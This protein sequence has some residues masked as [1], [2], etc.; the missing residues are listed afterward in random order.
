MQR[1]RELAPGVLVATSSFAT[2]TSTVVAGRDG[3]CLVIDPATTVAELAGLA[4]DLAAA[5]LHPVAGF[6]THPH[7]DHILWSDELGDV[8]RYAAPAAA[9]AA[10]REREEM[11]PDLA[12]SA[13]G[14]DLD[15]FAKLTA[16]PQDADRI[17]WDGPAARLI[18]HNAH[19]PGHTAVFLPELGVLVA[20][21][22][23]SDLEMPI[24][25]MTQPEQFAEYRAGL[26]RLAT[27]GEN[28]AGENAV[29]GESTVAGEGVAAGVR[30]LVPGHGHVG[31][32]AEF[33]RRVDADRRYLDLL[34]VGRP[35]E[36]PRTATVDWLRDWHETQLR[37]VSASG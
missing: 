23:L 28:R 32:A 1:L 21:D 14:H 15:L 35:F 31:D 6:A 4:A 13:P 34:A 36:D 37:A 3:G 5:G 9:E 2:T 33:R 29:A 11:L 25:D 19:A 16:L 20:G 10:R 30:W 17:P 24:L 22:M 12:E 7:W 26:D 8:P 18:T 27:A